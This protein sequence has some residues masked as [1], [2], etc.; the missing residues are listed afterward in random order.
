MAGCCDSLT[1]QEKPSLDELLFRLSWR[2][3]TSRRRFRKRPARTKTASVITILNSVGGS[4]DLPTQCLHLY[5]QN[6]FYR[7]KLDACN[8]M[9][10]LA[11]GNIVS[12]CMCFYILKRCHFIWTLFVF[13]MYCCFCYENNKDKFSYPVI[14]LTNLISRLHWFSR[15]LRQICRLPHRLLLVLLRAVIQFVFVRNFFAPNVGRESVIY[16]SLMRHDFFK[17]QLPVR[18]IF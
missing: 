8:G 11:F 15:D 2:P 18:T 14:Q 9:R 4:T 6:E 12:A 5:N 13:I 10:M 1:G 3:F 16:A 7:Q 17:L